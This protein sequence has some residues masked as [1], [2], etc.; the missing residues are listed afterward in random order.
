MIRDDLT[1]Y[2]R[3]SSSKVIIVA[4]VARFFENK[5]AKIN[6]TNNKGKKPVSYFTKGY[7]N[8]IA[9]SV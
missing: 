9:H 3:V 2:E 7:G 6:V 5:M 8:H 4:N 1:F